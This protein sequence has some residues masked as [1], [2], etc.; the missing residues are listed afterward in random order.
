[1]FENT[2]SRDPGAVFCRYLDRT[3][4]YAEAD[5]ITRAFAS[6]LIEAGTGRGDC[7]VMAIKKSEWCMLAPLAIV[8]AGA[9]YASVDHRV[10][11]EMAAMMIRETRAGIVL[12]DADTRERMEKAAGQFG[13]RIIDVSRFMESGA[14]R[15]LPEDT[16][17]DSIA[18]I[19]YT[20]GT[21]GVPKGAAVCHAGVINAAID[22][23][24]R[25]GKRGRCSAIA[26][27]PS[28]LAFHVEF[29]ACVYYGRAA[30]LVPDDLRYDI[31]S[32][33]RF[34]SE[35]G[36]DTAF[37]ITPLAKLYV[38]NVGETPL[39]TLNIGGEAT[40]CFEYDLDADLR[41]GYGCT[42]FGCIAATSVRARTDPSSVGRL[43]CNTK[44]YILDEEGR[45]VP[46][47]A[48]GILH[49]SGPPLTRGYL[50]RDADNASSFRGNPF[51]SEPGYER[52]FRVGDTARFLP[53]GTLA[54]LGRKDGQ[55]KIR[56]FRVELTE[57]E[58]AIRRC[59][60]VIDVCVTAP[61]LG[62]GTRSLVA[63]IVGRRPFDQEE[64]AKI[65]L[66]TKAAH[67][68]PSYVVNL[69][70]LPVGRTGKID[71]KSLPL[72]ESAGSGKNPS[73]IREKVICRHMSEVLGIPGIGPDDDFILLGGDS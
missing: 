18:Y 54:I 21:T 15:A 59:R 50:F 1:M 72:P 52:L 28:F 19:Q 53:D 62:S 57:V 73:D 30:V 39:K 35:N 6:E 56:G 12:V 32:L 49:V 65:V 36:I 4:T 31:A 7:V 3:I 2:V 45:R 22:D 69:E 48:A 8:R 63:Y 64:V 55:V 38:S 41:E 58:A 23:E 67:L 71:R 61:R 40:G 25:F 13:C 37:L 24:R 14:S 43:A 17:L 11:D 46:Y 29:W 47:G 60:D 68:V 16:S 51:C 66:E 27:T 5:R 26:S 70:R 34:Y 44:A 33:N 20:S 9:C 10:P 42:E